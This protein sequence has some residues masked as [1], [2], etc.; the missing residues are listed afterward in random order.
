MFEECKNVG[1]SLWVICV[2]LTPFNALFLIVWRTTFGSWRSMDLES[3]VGGAVF[4]SF[5]LFI[6]FHGV[7]GH[8]V[9]RGKLWAAQAAIVLAVLWILLGLTI[10]IVSL[11][12][13]SPFCL[14][15][16]VIPFGGA[17]CTRMANLAIAEIKSDDGWS[18]EGPLRDSKGF[19]VVVL[20]ELGRGEQTSESMR[21]R[22]TESQR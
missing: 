19:Q 12:A 21:H 7:A 13:G 2:L 14:I 9:G 5:F 15:G 6:L 11:A 8:F 17:S 3:L 16:L 18:R 10:A 20:S 22:G 1:R 4:V